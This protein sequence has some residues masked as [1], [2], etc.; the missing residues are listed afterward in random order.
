MA[1]TKP[2]V[3]PVARRAEIQQRLALKRDQRHQ[4]A[5]NGIRIDT[6][7]LRSPN[8]ARWQLTVDDK[9]KLTTTQTEPPDELQ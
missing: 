3:D 6:L 8:G 5:R 7:V 4:R 9:G 2:P 1:D